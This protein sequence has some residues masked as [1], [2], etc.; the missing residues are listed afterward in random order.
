MKAV[1]LE[2]RGENAAVLAGN[3][4]FIK[5]RQAGDVGEEIEIK[6]DQQWFN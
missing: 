5:V 6:E 3:G 1:I 4:T 2:R